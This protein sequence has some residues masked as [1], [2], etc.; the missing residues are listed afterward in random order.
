M[1]NCGASPPDP[2]ARIRH[3]LFDLVSDLPEALGPVDPGGDGAADR[4]GSVWSISHSGV[5]HVDPRRIVR[6]QSNRSDEVTGEE[7]REEIEPNLNHTCM[8][9]ALRP[10]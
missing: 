5:A 6:N 1:R 3:E 10:F 4:D 7:M 2:A 8:T 9:A